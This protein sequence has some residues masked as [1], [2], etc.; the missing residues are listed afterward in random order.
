MQK[1]LVGVGTVTAFIDDELYFVGKTLIDT[2]MEIST[3]STE[4]RGGQGNGLLAEYFH[5]SALN[6][7]ITDAQFRLPVLALNVGSPTAVSGGRLF[8][9]EEVT[10]VGSTG[11]LTNVAYDSIALVSDET[12]KKVYINYKDTYYSLDLGA[13]LTFDTSATS[14]P[15]NATICVSY[16]YN[17]PNS[18]TYTIPANYVPSRVHL[19][20][21]VKLSGNNTGEGYI[22]EETIEIPVFQLS[23]SQTLSMT[24]DGVSNTSLSGKA[25]AYQDS[26]VCESSGH[27]AKITETIYNTNWYDGV[28]GLA[29][30][31][32]DFTI[33]GLGNTSNLKVYAVKGGNSF[34]CD[35]SQLSFYSQTVATA[36]IGEH[37]GI[38]TTVA[39]GTTLLTAQITGV[40][41][42]LLVS[43][44]AD[45]TTVDEYIGYYVLYNGIDTLVTSANKSSVGITPGTTKAYVS[46]GNIEA[47]CTLTVT[48][49]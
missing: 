10:L 26:G 42:S 17:N 33:N 39:V 4:I 28:T 3:G 8:G 2:S 46:N 13:D 15:A 29:I 6:L 7:T 16:L 11:T 41:N 38:V 19:F 23:G 49:A 36:T 20:V 32:G 1:Y 24:A 44:Y 45:F 47:S 21:S 37:T 9:N 40:A 25:I 5:D 30:M 18:I 34:L 22:G 48:N 43:G 14:I 27:Y 35:N 31:G 12:Q